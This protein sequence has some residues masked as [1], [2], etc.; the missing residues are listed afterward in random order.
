MNKHFLRSLLA[1]VLLLA[2]CAKKTKIYSSDEAM[3]EFTPSY[4]DFEYLSAKARVAMEEENGKTTRGTLNL[5]AKRDSIIWFSI[6]PGLG[7]EAAR[8]MITRE[9]IKVIDRINNKDINLTF[10]QFQNTYGLKLSLDLFQNVLFAN[11]PYGVSYRDRLIRVGKTFELTQR[12][13]GI[14]YESVIGVQHGKVT[15]LTTASRFHKGKLSASY[16][17]FEDLD[18]QPYA[19]KILLKLLM[20]NASSDVQS[21]LVNLEF[22]KVEL[23]DTPLSFPY[24]F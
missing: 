16:P 24:N 1:C 23:Q 4:F 7:I 20:E 17:E 13:D 9:D 22:N 19:Y 6:S 10:D 21:T 3:K 14:T 5:R 15:E 11:I 2:G 18:G 8:G 12:R